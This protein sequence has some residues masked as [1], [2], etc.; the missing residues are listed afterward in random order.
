MA[1]KG[2]HLPLDH[3]L[4]PSL[5]VKEEEGQRWKEQVKPMR[6]PG[7][8]PQAGH[9]PPTPGVTS[10]GQAF[11]GWT[12]RILLE[13][14]SRKTWKHPGHFLSTL[15]PDSMNKAESMPGCL[16]G[17]WKKMN[18]LHP[19]LLE[20]LSRPCLSHPHKD[21]LIPHQGQRTPGFPYPSAYTGHWD[22]FWGCLFNNPSVPQVTGKRLINP[23][24]TEGLVS[25]HQSLDSRAKHL[26]L[27]LSGAGRAQ[28]C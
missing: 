7:R 4:M 23:K 27:F 21:L 14:P 17:Y 9:K 6:E 24:N 1:K 25:G 10:P 12:C 28:M 26:L 16:R 13:S 11:L 8:C 20:Q 18:I 2:S 3:H 19:W 5:W 15:P 22:L